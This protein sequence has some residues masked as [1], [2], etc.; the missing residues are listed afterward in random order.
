M[1]K[2]EIVKT[3]SYKLNQGFITQKINNKT[4]IFSGEDSVLH[5]LNETAALI[6][7]GIKLG[8]NKNKIAEKLMDKYG[9]GQKKALQDIDI[10]LDELLSK[11]I[12][13]ES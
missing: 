11:K 8:W 4:T 5:T 13:S 9:I 3:K 2:S 12:I 1:K 10:L 7:N 6:F